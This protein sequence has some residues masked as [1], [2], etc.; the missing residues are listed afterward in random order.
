MEMFISIGSTD[1]AYLQ[2]V[3]IQKAL[4]TEFG[5]PARFPILRRVVPEKGA[6]TEIRYFYEGQSKKALRKKLTPEQLKND[7]PDF[8]LA[9]AASAKLQAAGFNG[10]IKIIA[11]DDSEAPENFLQISFAV[12][13][14]D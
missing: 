3:R 9:Q 1:A 13:S 2:A 7:D 5:F 14:L 6:S 11:I 12:G 10:P 4:N 8:K